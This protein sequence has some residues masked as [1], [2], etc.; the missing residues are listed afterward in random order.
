MLA[1]AIAAVMP[2]FAQEA[3]P[4]TT[5]K[6]V[7]TQKTETDDAKLQKVE[8]RGSAE[9][10]D[11]RR[12]DTASKIVVNHEEIVKYGDT[13]VLDVL[14]R[15]P[16]VTVS[17]A[18][19][20]GG[21]IRM[22]GLGSGY[23]QIL[24]NGER[25]PAGF[26]MDTLSPDVIERIEVLRAASAEFSTQ[27]IAGTINIVLK[28][29]IKNAQRELKLG[30]G[31]GAG[32]RSPTANLQLSDRAGKM[33][34][35]LTAN[36]FQQ[37]FDR[38]TGTVEQ[39]YN[40]AG[41]QNLLRNG[42]SSE[43]GRVVA[44]NL[45]PRLHWTF[46]GG[47]TL[48]SQS[49]LNVNR[50]RVHGRDLS[51][52]PLGDPPPYPV[53]ELS[54]TNDNEFFRTDLNWVHKL[55]SGAKLDTK[56]GAV[57]GSLANT[58]YRTGTGNPA[59]ADWNRVTDSNGTDRG[60]TSTGKYTDPLWEGHSL[61]IGWDGGYSTRDDERHER[62]FVQPETV[63][64]G[65]DENYRARVAR[66]A[67]YA[68]DE[69]NV[70]KSWSVYL[71]MRWEGIRTRTE[72]NTFATAESRSSVWSPLLQTLWKLPGTK[73][74]QV[75]F[76][77][78]R[79]YKAPGLQSLVPHRYSSVNNS[80]VAPD[81]QGN[82]NLKPELALG[83]DASYEHYWG[84]GGLLSVSTSMR[85]IDDYTRYLTVF[86]DARWVALPMNA[87]RAQTR[88]LELE[89][90]FPLKSL[91]A[92]APAI[93]LRANLSRN[94]SS[95]DSVPGPNNRLDQQTPLSANFGLDYKVGALTTGGSFG[96]KN[97]GVVQVSDRQ[98]AYVSVRRDLDLYALWKFDPKNQLRVAVSNVLG[99]D[100]INERSYAGTD[101]E[102]RRR[103]LYPATAN[104]RATMEMKF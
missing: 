104:V 37:R 28:K 96:F 63:I 25:A 33:S 95:V 90:K 99:Q 93:D 6:P 67:M 12:D 3:Q 69:W 23:T 20:R 1:G 39:G 24:I 35:S 17:G 36:L 85:R 77:V 83:F 43:V 15:V 54:L 81:S 19:G 53:G 101:G 11:P 102:L 18:A 44:M 42:G 40:L 91:M 75:R 80:Q 46:D 41:A 26:S 97:G 64:A 59:Y 22:R 57:V 84:E 73:G 30:Y 48:T 87:G 58:N 29:A 14:K 34:Y 88:G 61:A 60:L 89:A 82:P 72:G 7:V 2:A 16:G 50:F 27:S 4:A 52:T 70:T 56:I 21:E 38:D 79:T 31:A 86:E 76:A 94:W 103:W 55:K 10:Y 8:V 9:A 78:T 98:A 49:F 5:S 92:N 74:D 66:L 13:N 65:G 32:V 68:Q 62:D 47:D 51:A 100:F 45:S 71:G